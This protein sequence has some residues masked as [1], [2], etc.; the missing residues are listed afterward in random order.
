MLARSV[1]VPA[2]LTVSFAAALRGDRLLLVVVTC[3]VAAVAAIPLVF[4]VWNSFKPVGGAIIADFSLSNWTLANFARAYSDP[5]AIQMLGNSFVFAFGSMAV[6]FAFGG[7]LAFLVERT[8]APFRNAIYA[9]MF[10][11]LAMPGMLKAIGWILLIS[12]R[13]GI[14]NQV[15]MA[16]GL[17]GPIVDAYTIPA[18]FWVEGLSMAPLT[19]LMLGAALRMMDPALE[20]AALMSGAGAVNTA[21]RITLR[22]MWPALA[23]IAL[24][25]F[26][27]GLE[28]FD[29]PL[30]MG[31]SNGILV[32]ST[33]IYITMRESFP[34]RY[35]EGFA[36][37]FTLL[38]LAMIGV[39]LYQRSLNRYE[40][41]AT[42]TGKGFRPRLIDLGRWRPLAAALTILFIFFAV[43]APLIAL[44]WASFLR[45]YQMPT[46]QALQAVSFENYRILFGRDV[47]TLTLWNSFVVAAVVSVSVMLLSTG[48]SWLVIRQRTSGSKVLDYLV[49][50]AFAVPS[51]AVGFSFMVLFLS[52]PNPIYGTLSIMILPYVASFLPIGTRFTHAAMAQ[53]SKELEEAATAS[54]AGLFGVMRRVTVPLMLPAL[55]A[56]GLYIF[57]LSAKVASIPMLLHTPETPVLPVLIYRLWDEG[58]IGLT[59]AMSVVM[60]LGLIVLIIAGR[61]LIQRGSVVERG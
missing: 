4:L 52:F 27:R 37:S 55:V 31:L 49:F 42:I 41:Y 15:W 3:V 57:L 53:L 24:L 18:M 19:F 12:P 48:V 38:V 51:I 33:N 60:I 23:G 46:L 30:I 34:P 58:S 32:F 13:I 56:G 50:S 36:Y 9:F 26:V 21:Y 11:P 54:G 8:N 47:F 44:I 59:S 29:V 5:R 14:F 61:A 1:A 2:R 28:S 16:L 43:L 10:I 39:L 40:R 25:Q 20:E 35:G 45:F 22:L 6:A 7:S 17:P